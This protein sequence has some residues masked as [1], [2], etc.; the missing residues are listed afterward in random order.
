MN[1]AEKNYYAEYV[2][3]DGANSNSLNY[4]LN[5]S[6][7]LGA[8]SSMSSK[9]ENSFKKQK[10]NEVQDIYDDEHYCMARSSSTQRKDEAQI[11]EETPFRYKKI[12]MICVVLI[13]LFLFAIFGGFVGSLI[14]RNIGLK[15][16]INKY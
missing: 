10:N 16:F 9:F 8:R 6:S 1:S 14:N 7:V 5:T 13:F 15:Y 12:L 11:N 4:N 3:D 2:Y